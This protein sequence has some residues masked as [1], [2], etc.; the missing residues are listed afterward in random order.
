MQPQAWGLKKTIIIKGIIKKHGMI[1]WIKDRVRNGV[2]LCNS[3]LYSSMIETLLFESWNSICCKVVQSVRALMAVTTIETFHNNLVSPR[4]QMLV[5]PQE[6]VR[7]V[8]WNKYCN[9]RFLNE[10]RVSVC[11]PSM[12]V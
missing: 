6:K 4:F 8:S 7:V 11:V 9:E 3:C 10:T 1:V 2:S 5:Q 12:D